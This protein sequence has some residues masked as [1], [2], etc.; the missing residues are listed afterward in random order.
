MKTERLK[1]E[2][3]AQL[4]NLDKIKNNTKFQSSIHV[5]SVEPR[6]KWDG[7]SNDD[8]FEGSKNSK[9]TSREQN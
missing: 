2:K 9:T 8:R 3:Q 7:L 1:F 6:D 4:M 5:L